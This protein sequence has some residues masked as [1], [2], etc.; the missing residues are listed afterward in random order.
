MIIV[1]LG[2]HRG[3]NSVAVSGPSNEI[4]G[5][6]NQEGAADIISL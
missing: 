3:R 2:E 4:E 5:G 6:G 1:E